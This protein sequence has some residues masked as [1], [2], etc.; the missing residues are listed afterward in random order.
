[1]VCFARQQQ[2]LVLMTNSDNGEWAFAPLVKSFWAPDALPVE[3][4]SYTPDAL[5]SKTN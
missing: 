5:R 3:W 1:M 2:C 4:M